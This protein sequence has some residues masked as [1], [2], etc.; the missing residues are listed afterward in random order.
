M[1][2]RPL[3]EERENPTICN[4]MA[5]LAWYVLGSVAMIATILLVAWA[6]NG[7]EP[8]GLHGNVL[9]ALILGSVGTA[10]LAIALM[11]LVFHS[12]R[13]GQDETDR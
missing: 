4:V 7:F 2:V 12:H 9:I 11:A 3:F 6:A 1:S 5:R 10:A 13:S 8:I